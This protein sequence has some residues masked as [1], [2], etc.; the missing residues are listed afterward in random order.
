M[1]S[2][3]ELCTLFYL[4]DIYFFKK[5]RKQRIKRSRSFIRTR[6]RAAV[7]SL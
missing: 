2:A 6:L 4:Y 1:I 7:R 5:K 3:I